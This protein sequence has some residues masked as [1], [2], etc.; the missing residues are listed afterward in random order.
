[1]KLWQKVF[2]C[3]LALMVLAVFVTSQVVVQLSFSATEE[4]EIQRTAS[5]HAF[6]S[7]GISS[8]VAYER[9]RQDEVFLSAGEVESLLVRSIAG[10]VGSST[11]VEIYREG[12]RVASGNTPLELREGE[13]LKSVEEAPPREGE[14]RTMIRE[15]EG[16]YYVVCVSSLLLEGNEYELYTVREVTEI[17]EERSSLLRRTQGILLIFS[18]VMA[19]VLFLVLRLWLSPLGKINGTINEIAR[20]IGG[21]NARPGRTGGN[22][23]P[24]CA[25][26]Y[27]PHR[28]GWRDCPLSL[29]HL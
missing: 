23:F 24:E 21:A 5:E 17:Y 25:G 13:I 28:R 7:G 11:G 12:K 20:G 26:K 9:S 15:K 18:L 29:E 16:A 6:F 1:M 3:A 19:A 14:G 8:R 27:L 2:L 22:P 4:R 10:Q